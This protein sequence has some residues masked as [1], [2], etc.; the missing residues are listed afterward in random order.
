[1]IFQKT[2]PT[3]KPMNMDKQGAAAAVAASLC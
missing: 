2:S 1:M 3:M